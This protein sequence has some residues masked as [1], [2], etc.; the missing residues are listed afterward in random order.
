MDNYRPQNLNQG[1]LDLVKI[2]PAISLEDHTHNGGGGELKIFTGA[3]TGNGA[4]AYAITGIGFQPKYVKIWERKTA[5]FEKDEI[6]ETT[7]TIVDDNAEG[8]CWKHVGSGSH[9]TRTNGIISLD[10]DGFTV[11]DYGVDSD[12][13]KDGIVY[14]YLCMG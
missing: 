4:S 11:D 12:P 3:Y 10:S 7:D 8:Q 5:H 13:N 6:F 1:D 2:Y 9:S 14:N